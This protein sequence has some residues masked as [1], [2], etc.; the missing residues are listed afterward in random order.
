MDADRPPQAHTALMSV[1]RMEL[2]AA[3]L[4]SAA[5]CT[6][7]TEPE[8]SEPVVV[9]V[10]SDWSMFPEA[11]VSGDLSV[12]DAGCVRLG[13]RLVVWPSGTE[14]D[15]S[16]EA[17]VFADGATASLKEGDSFEGGGGS[18][19]MRIWREGLDPDEK[20]AL[21]ACLTA[22]DDEHALFAYP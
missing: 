15:T 18:L 9:T 1:W 13:D 20:T 17:L 10:E 19:P 5:G 12:D 7:E 21:E 22:M 16:A 6:G 3:V 14:W 8:A 2:A 4:F 11:L